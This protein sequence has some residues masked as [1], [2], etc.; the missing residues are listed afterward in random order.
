MVAIWPRPA[1]DA[2]GEIGQDVPTLLRAAWPAHAA[3]RA[4]RAADVPLE[5]ARNWLRGRGRPLAETLLKMAARD[6]DMAG[7]LA[8]RLDALRANRAAQNTRQDAPGHRTVDR[9]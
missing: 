2:S 6:A 7:A 5:T 3:K 4:A 1:P 9:S 8:A